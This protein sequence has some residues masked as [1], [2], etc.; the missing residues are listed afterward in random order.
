MTLVDA[1]L[2]YSLGWLHER[3]ATYVLFK[4]GL[5]NIR[6]NSKSHLKNSARFSSPKRDGVAQQR[7]RLMIPMSS[8]PRMNRKQ[9]LSNRVPKD[10]NAEGKGI[11]R[12]TL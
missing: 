6:R 11:G 4:T 10:Q 12:L 9:W 8:R 3:N 2:I 5:F 1:R 7:S